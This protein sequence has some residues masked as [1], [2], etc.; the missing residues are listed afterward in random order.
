MNNRVGLICDTHFGVRRGSQIFHDY[1]E[2]FFEKTFFPTLRKNKIDTVVHLGDCF[3]VRKN[4]DYW[5]LAWAKRVFFDPL[6]KR[7]IKL[8]MLVGNH[9][10][11]YK[12]TLK[13]NAPSLNLSEY[14]NV[15]IYDSPITIQLKDT[16]I[17][18]VPWVCD[19]N[20]QEFIDKRDLSPAKIVM[21]HLQIA[22]F[23]ANQNY[24]CM[25]GLDMQVFSKFDQVFSGHFHKKSTSGNITYLGN[26]YQ[27]YWNDEGNQRGFHLYDLNTNELEFIP[28][29]RN[30][31]Y[32][33]NYK[34]GNVVDTN[35][36]KDSYVKILVEKG[37]SQQNLAMLVDVINTT[38]VHD[39]KVI[40]SF[41]LTIDDDVEVEG[42]DTLTTLTNYISNMNDV[43]KDNLIQIFKT[44]YQ[45]AY[46]G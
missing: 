18:M 39:L 5:S 44:L 14:D 22:G 8:H 1:F 45:E 34:E 27:M 10:A 4:I 43:N 38:G 33:L 12:N 31:F 26:P 23:Y 42:E 11:F 40:E 21:G 28:N 17:Y 37:A 16:P 15:I 36:F 2:E 19:D 29:K 7:G 13:I 30:M 25:D 32:K 41:D 46:D 6:E 35:K 9:D 20:A 3:D 24:Q